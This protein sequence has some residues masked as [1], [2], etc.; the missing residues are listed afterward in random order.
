MLTH[1][2]VPQSTKA[3]FRIVHTDHSFIHS[4]TTSEQKE[5]K[6]KKNLISR[7]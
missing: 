2:K 5:K 4:S 1:D 3:E 7:Y 6:T